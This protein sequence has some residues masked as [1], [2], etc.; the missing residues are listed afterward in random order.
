MA[1]TIEGM[2]F[3]GG[4]VRGAILG[5]WSPYETDAAG[6]ISAAHTIWHTGQTYLLARPEMLH[7]D[8][9]ALAHDREG[10]SHGTVWLTLMCV[11]SRPRTITRDRFPIDSGP[12]RRALVQDA[13]ATLHDLAIPVGRDELRLWLDEFLDYLP[14]PDG[15]TSAPSA[16]RGGW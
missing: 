6:A 7:F 14:I 16:G 2:H 5:G 15:A 9:G 13:W 8:F 10:E 1:D 4:Q 12:R 11:G 3:P